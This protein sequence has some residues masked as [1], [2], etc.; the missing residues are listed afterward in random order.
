MSNCF[1]ATSV[2]AVMIVDK[3][4]DAQGLSTPLTQLVISALAIPKSIFYYDIA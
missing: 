1:V 3:D 4:R 2:S